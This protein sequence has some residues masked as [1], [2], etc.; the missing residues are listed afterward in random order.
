MI[1]MRT[2]R[3]DYRQMQANIFFVRRTRYADAAPSTAEFRDSGIGAG[4][5]K[6]KP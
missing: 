5:S 3:F 1:M 4:G 2:C 6:W